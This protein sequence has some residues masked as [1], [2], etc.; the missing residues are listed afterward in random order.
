MYITCKCMQAIYIYM[1]LYRILIE[2]KRE[3]ERER[4]KEKENDK[5]QYIVY[6]PT[7]D[8]PIRHLYSND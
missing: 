1:Y 3:T 7:Y 5:Q 4:E 8:E 6:T 2:R